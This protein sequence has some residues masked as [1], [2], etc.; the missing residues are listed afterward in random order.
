MKINWLWD[1]HVK[2]DYVRKILKD[3]NHPEFYIFAEKL[4]ARVNDPKIIFEYMDK[5]TFCRKWPIIKK[6]VQKDAWAIDRVNFWQTIYDRS[7][8]ELK[9]HGFQVRKS[10]EMD[11]P[12][13]RLSIAEQIKSIRIKLGYT[14]KDLAKKLGVIQ[15]Y[16]S[17][18]ETGR[19]NVSIDNLKRIAD[20]LNRHLVVR[21]R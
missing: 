15:Q 6:R 9:E 16:V 12:P 7:L 1:M 21:L 13:E 8:I 10:A 14:Q 3:K 11:I 2:E 5:K 18:L 19:E 4:F 20:V 17:R